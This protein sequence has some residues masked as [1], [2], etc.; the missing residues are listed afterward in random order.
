LDIRDIEELTVGATW[1]A[2]AHRLAHDRVHA[3]AS[4]D[5]GC[6]AYLFL[7]GSAQPH[8]DVS[9]FITIAEQLGLPFNRN[10]KFLQF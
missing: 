2:R 9:I 3:I 6:L 5:E 1:K 7:G 8:D 10:A 4:G